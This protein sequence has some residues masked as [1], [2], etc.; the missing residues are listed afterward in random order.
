MPRHGPPAPVGTAP[1]RRPRARRSRTHPPSSRV[2]PGVRPG[3]A[4]RARLRINHSWQGRIGCTPP[5]PPK[6]VRRYF[7]CIP[8]AASPSCQLCACACRSLQ[9]CRGG[10]GGADAQ[11]AHPATFSTAPAHQRL[12]TA[13]AETTPARAPAAA[14]N[15]KQRPDATCEG[16]N[17]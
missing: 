9:T 16:T 15:R 11:T 12:G 3:G 1:Q 17:G 7:D 13:N 8:P 2:G 10:G 5:L 4:S 6:I 14:A